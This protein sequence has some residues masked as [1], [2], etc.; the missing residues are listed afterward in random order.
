MDILINIIKYFSKFPAK[1]GVLRNFKRSAGILEGYDDLFDY[2]TALPAG[3]LGDI[4]EFI[5]STNEEVI[6]ERIRKI[7]SYFMLLEYSSL[8]SYARNNAG[9]RESAMNLSVI[10]AYPGNKPGFDVIDEA[11]VMN[12]TLELAVSIAKQM[13]ADNEDLC[14]DKRY[15]S[16]SVTISPVEPVMIY[17]CYGWSL[18]FTKSEPFFN[19]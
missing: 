10:I 3:L 4:K 7:S 5:I 11:L 2:I 16:S 6:A 9:I 15:M 18:T 1:D 12:K 14:S 19:E 17:G 13:E 8:I